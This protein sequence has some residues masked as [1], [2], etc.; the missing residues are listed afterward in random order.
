MGLGKKRTKSMKNEQKT[1]KEIFSV[2]NE[3]KIVFVRFSLPYSSVTKIKI[4]EKR[5]KNGENR[6][7]NREN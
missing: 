2:K 3:Q 4:C 1:K 5:T 6:K 7:K